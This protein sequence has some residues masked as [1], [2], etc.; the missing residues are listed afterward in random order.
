MLVRLALLALLALAAPTPAQDTAPERIVAGLSQSRVAI[1]ADFAGSKIM[2]YGAIARE[3]PAPDTGPMAVLVTV[4]GPGQKI[5]VRRKERHFGI[6][7]NT[8]KVVVQDVPSF[9]AAASTQTF[10]E[11]LNLTDD[12]RHGITLNHLFSAEPGGE[13]VAHV[14]AILRIRKNA[15]H[16]RQVDYGVMLSEDTLFRAD[17]DLPADLIEGDYLVRIFLTRAGTVVDSFERSIHVR[18][19]GLERFFYRMAQDQP[20]RYGFLSLIVA[21][22][23]GWG[24]SALFARLRW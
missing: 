14:A 20:L 24:A 21:V 15:D 2:I 8:E 5:V 4:E 17:V 16:F 18:K 11:T 1:T 12:L 22:V 7:L 6:W 9:Y 3:A 10:G 13:N 23:A 19:A